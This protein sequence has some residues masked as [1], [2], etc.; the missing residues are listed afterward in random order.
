[1]IIK[2]MIAATMLI[3]LLPGVGAC[4]QTRG[5][6]SKRASSQTRKL[7][8]RARPKKP[9]AHQAI[10]VVAAL[11][12]KFTDKWNI[13]GEIISVSGNN[14]TVRDERGL[15]TVVYLFPDTAYQIETSS[16]TVRDGDAKMIFSPLIVEVDGL[17]NSSYQMKAIVIRTTEAHL[18]RARA[19]QSIMVKP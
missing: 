4:V 11:E 17:L 7:R 18:N 16:G 3:S 8:K 6:T 12:D 9:A 1:M 2:R 5:A 15:D 10:P 19:L 13:K 14:F